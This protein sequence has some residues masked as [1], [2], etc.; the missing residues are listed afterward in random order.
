MKLAGQK[1][2]VTGG[3][4]GIGLVLVPGLAVRILRNN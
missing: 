4:A 1:E 2:L 3:S